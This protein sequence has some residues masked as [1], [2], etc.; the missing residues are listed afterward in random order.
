MIDNE[1]CLIKNG[2]VESVIVSNESFATTYAA[3]N[4]FIAVKRPFTT[5]GIGQTYHDSKFYRT[6]NDICP[7]GMIHTG[8]TA[9]CTGG[10]PLSTTHE[11]EI[12]G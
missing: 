3:D 12:T 1:F 2:V 8:Q 4:G 6:V 7:G 10:E 5:V 11:E 9:P